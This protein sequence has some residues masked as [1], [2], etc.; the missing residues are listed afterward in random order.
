MRGGAGGRRGRGGRERWRALPTEPFGNFFAY[1]VKATL[2]R[3]IFFLIGASLVINGCVVGMMAHLIGIDGEHRTRG[4]ILLGLFVVM[5][6]GVSGKI[7]RRLTRPFLELAR[8]AQEIGKGNLGARYALSR[9]GRTGEAFLI[10]LSINEMAARIEK[11]LKDQRELLAAVSH[12]VRTPLARIRMLVELARSQESPGSAGQFLVEGKALDDLDRE[13][14]EIDALIGELL[15]SSRVDFA[16]LTKSELDAA[17]VARRAVERQTLSPAPTLVLP[18]D[19]LLFQADATLIQ[20]ALA[21]L[22]QNA[23]VHAGGVES[24]VVKRNGEAVRF[25]V[26]DRGPGLAEGEES[27]IFASFYRGAGAG[28]GAGSGGGANDTHAALGLG[29]ALVQRIAQ[30]HGGRS[31]A[32]RRPEGGGA[33]IGFEVPV[34]G[35]TAPSSTAPSSTEG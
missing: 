3:R 23:V 9:H 11:Q 15:A 1:Y 6:W 34:G 5:L 27:K 4:W 33:S 28:P 20:R 26:N 21:N 14:I 16:A 30:A 8:V 13:V 17:D 10:G 31:F 35:A 22:L 7:A 12:E 24:L 32:Q 29:L 25:E 19:P 2:H 18:D